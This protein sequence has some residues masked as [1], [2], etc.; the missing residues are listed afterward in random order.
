MNTRKFN[1][2]RN[3]RVLGIIL[4]TMLAALSCQ[5]ESVVTD[6]STSSFDKLVIRAEQEGGSSKTTVDSETGTV[7]WEPEDSINVFYGSN[8]LKFI[9]HNQEKSRIA[10]FVSTEQNVIIGVNDGISPFI[11]GLYPFDKSAVCDGKTI[12]TTLEP[13]QTASEGTFS[14]NTFITLGKYSSEASVMSFY[15]VCGGIRF[16][17]AKEGIDKVVFLGNNN[18]VL[19]GQVKLAFGEDGYPEVKEVLTGYG[20]VG[21]TCKEG[22]KTDVWYYLATL[23][24]ELSKGYSVFLISST[25]DTIEAISYDEPIEIK[26]SCFGSI[27]DFKKGMEWG[28]TFFSYCM[29]TYDA[30]GDFRISESEAEA[31][32]ELSLNNCGISSLKGIEIFKNL[33]SLECYSNSL[34]SL[35]I[36]NNTALTYLDCNNNKLTS[37]DVSKNTALEMLYC[38]DNQINELWFYNEAQKNGIRYLDTD[39]SVTFKY[40]YSE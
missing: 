28:Y 30:D 21:L 35:D 36:S 15:N 38:T 13:E 39:P 31:V 25:S 9:T 12:T 19:A 3:I 20:F 16:K 8:M 22:F 29:N 33:Q 18:E 4:A 5:K 10:D 37:L 14:N 27:T 26:R 2:M 6:S 24:V 34:T 7:Y 23:P 11:V 17:I 1:D 40:Y 32:T